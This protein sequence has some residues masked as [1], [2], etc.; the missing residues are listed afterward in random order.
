MSTKLVSVGGLVLL[1]VLFFALN[2]WAGSATRRVRVDLTQQSLFTL[3]DGSKRIAR[4]F[5]EPVK[6]TFYYSA[7]L[8][9]GRPGVQTYATRVREMLEEYASAS[10]GKI[11]LKIVDPE[12]SSDAEDSAVQ[13]GLQGVPISATDS[14]YFGLVG[15]N[16]VD[17]K[18]VIPFFDPGTERFLEYDVSRFLYSLANPKKKTVGLM[19]GLKM[20]GGGFD[21]TTGQMSRQPPWQVMRELRGLFQVKTVAMTETEIP[22]DVDVLLVV[23]PKNLSDATLFA[24]DQYVLKGGKLVAL[25][26]PHCESDDAGADPR[27]PMAAMMAP[28]ASSLKKL[29][30]AWGME[31]VDASIV[32]DINY[33]TPVNM[34]G[35]QGARPEPVSYVAWLNMDAKAFSA[36]EPVTGNLSRM[37]FAT[38]GAIRVSSPLAAGEAAKAEDSKG[39]EGEE[40]KSADEKKVDAAK[41]V[42]TSSVV[43]TPLV[44]SSEQAM[45]V[46]Q[47]SVQ[48]MPDPKALLTN[49]VPGKESLTI[50]ARVS[51]ASGAKL[52][53]AFPEGK[54]VGP[55]EQG[56]APVPP[57]GDPKAGLVTESAGPLNVIVIADADFI[58]DRFWTQRDQFFGQTA[59]IADNGDFLVNAVD[60]LSGSSD[61]IGIR[62][63]GTFNRPFDRVIAM[64]KV[65]EQSY[66]SQEK[67]L[68]DKVQQ[69]QTKIT[70]LQSQKPAG[71]GAML[72][73]P[74]QQTEI[75]KLRKEMAAS[76]KELRQVRF[77]LRRDIDGLYDRL[78]FLNI[79]FIPAL[80]TLGAVGLGWYRV[81][82]QRSTT[83]TSSAAMPD[84]AGGVSQKGAA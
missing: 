33:A 47:A 80:V 34:G 81:S 3:T 52:K 78:K 70:Q 23:H 26:D 62:A 9:Q 53:T 42:V 83:Q 51:L 48:M 2:L 10:G 68:E 77:N 75:D 55:P 45:L 76:N 66:R 25:V 61:L 5:E 20:D 6:L 7:K 36:E 84:L 50:A 17:G 59:K 54:P 43:L 4:S 58:N 79:V 29:F 21:P 46:P 60:N 69:A 64:Q 16:A 38:A 73:S 11:K 13:A 1:L 28:K 41:P 35:Q 57:P 67:E 65:A 44:R 31:V 12:P 49:Y 72:L 30:D 71:A 27:N 63:R 74:E 24:I 22:A 18:E 56:Q 19:T 40:R 14:L 39:V 8:A 37:V 32:G 15:T 82:R